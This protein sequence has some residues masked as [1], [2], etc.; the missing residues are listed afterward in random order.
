[1]NANELRIGNIVTINNHQSHLVMQGV[2]VAVKGITHKAGLNNF[3]TYSI[4]LELLDKEL[5]KYY[6]AY[7]QYIE[8]IE[9]IQ[10]T[11]EWLVRLG[12]KEKDRIYKN[13]RIEINIGNH[14]TVH[15]IGSN[16][17]YSIPYQH[18]K[19]SIHWLQNLYFSLTS[20]ELTI[21]N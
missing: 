4:Y 12:F 16:G 8:F 7:N 2:P 13:D 20:K 9:P 5:N 11:E 1:M 6:Q 15:I 14:G 10:L 19:H 17:G 21:N 3:M 18:G